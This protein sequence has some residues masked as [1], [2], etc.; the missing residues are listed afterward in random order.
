MPIAIEEFEEQTK[1]RALRLVR[2]RVWCIDGPEWKMTL[3]A[4]DR[5]SGERWAADLLEMIEARYVNKNAQR[6]ESP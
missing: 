1:H 6:K 3:M 2:F 4:E 5:Q